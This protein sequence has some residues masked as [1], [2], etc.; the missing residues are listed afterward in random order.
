MSLFDANLVEIN[1]YYMFKGKNGSNLLV[2]IDDEK[3]E[4]MLKD[5][6]KKESVEVLTTKWSTMNWKEQ[7]SSVERA[8]S[9]VNSLTGDK[10]FDHVSYRDSIIKSCLKQWNIVVN[11]QTVPV[12]PD[13][14]DKLPGDVVMALYSKYE[15]ILDYTDEELK[16]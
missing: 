10:T 16:N 2:I 8:Y 1:L 15:K 9:K 13:A 12:T 7:N 6:S 14:I 3:A 4:K 5:D 11:G